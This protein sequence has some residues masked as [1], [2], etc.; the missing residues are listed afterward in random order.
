MLLTIV[1]LITDPMSLLLQNLFFY[2]PLYNTIL[3]FASTF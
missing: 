3:H 2:I 1:N